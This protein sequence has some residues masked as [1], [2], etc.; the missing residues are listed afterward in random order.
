MPRLSRAAVNP[1]EGFS[2]YAGASPNQVVAYN[3]ARAR[4]YREWTQDQAREALAPYLGVEWSKANYSAA[5]RSMDGVRVR[6]FDADEI[7]AFARAF[8]VPLAWFFLPPDPG[9][10]DGVLI[11][12]STPDATA[13]AGTP[14]GELVDL[15]YG[16]D[17]MAN[18]MIL[19]LGRFMEGYGAG[20]M[21]EAQRRITELANARKAAVVAESFRGLHY[22]AT[23]L[24]ALANQLEELALKAGVVS[25]EELGVYDG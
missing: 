21:T 2:A 16:D 4:A 18:L 22:G 11:R 14:M 1:A 15:V 13:M 23:N 12:L 10:A 5:E 8:R 25:L 6:Q 3:L 19:M 7:V 20:G 9:A 17:E 24:R